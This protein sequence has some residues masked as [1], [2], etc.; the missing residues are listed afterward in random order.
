M[1]E[2]P[3]GSYK[4]CGTTTCLVRVMRTIRGTVSLMGGE[5]IGMSLHKH[6][7]ITYFWVPIGFFTN[8]QNWQNWHYWQLC[9]P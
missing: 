2:Q 6:K 3:L 7:H 4:I 8:T 9:I 1:M 5:A